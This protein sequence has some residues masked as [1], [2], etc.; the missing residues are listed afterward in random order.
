EELEW[1][2]GDILRWLQEK[3]LT[4]RIG[5][6]YPLSEAAQAHRDLEG[7]KTVGKLILTP[8]PWP[9]DQPHRLRLGRLPFPHRPHALRSLKLDRYLIHLDR[10]RLR[11][12]FANR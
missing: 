11:H 12:R 6:T 10:Q 1:R 3:K 8:G 4:V 2:A 7:R 9:L 5:H